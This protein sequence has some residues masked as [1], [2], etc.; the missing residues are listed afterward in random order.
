MPTP[1][2]C[3]AH[4]RFERLDAA[5]KAGDLA[6]L[7]ADAEGFPHE[8]LHPAIG[9]C[10]PYA[11]FWSPLAFIEELLDAGADPNAHENDRYPP[12]IAA[13]DRDRFDDLHALLRLLLARGADPNIHGIN[14]YTALH[15]AAERGDLEAVELL[16][17]HGADPNEA[18]RI[19]DY[20]T[21]LDLAAKAG[22]TRVAARLAPLT[23]P[24]RA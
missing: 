7:R 22:Q 5:F 17:A 6:A 19:D 15:L 1:E 9:L 11:I 12:L 16:L 23:R 20:E 21:A 3:A 4:A 14:D 10:L 13:F 2:E 8:P 24:P 18:T